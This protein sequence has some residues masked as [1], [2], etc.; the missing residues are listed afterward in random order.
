MT[1]PTIDYSHSVRCIIDNGFRHLP[2][3]AELAVLIDKATE[4]EQ[5]QLHLRLIEWF[6]EEEANKL[7]SAAEVFCEATP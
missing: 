2:S 4:D 6:G 3:P 7:W 1:E 5:T